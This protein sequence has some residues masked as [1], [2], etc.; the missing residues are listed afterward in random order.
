MRTFTPLAALRR[1]MRIRREYATL[2]DLPD[3][4]LHDMGISRHRIPKQ[5]LFRSGRN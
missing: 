1:R 5:P 2:R 3:D 4:L